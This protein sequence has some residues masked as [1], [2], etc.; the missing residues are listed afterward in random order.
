MI[1]L[2]PTL[3]R[4]QLLR[5]SALLGAAV[6]L[7]TTA[8]G[9]GDSSSGELTVW[10]MLGGAD[11]RWS[12]V[13]KQY[14][15]TFA[16]AGGGVQV[17]HIN[18]TNDSTTYPQLLQS[19]FQA[20]SGPDVIM[21]Q[22]AGDGVLT[23]AEGLRPLDDYISAELMSAVSGW[24]DNSIDGSIYGASL[25]IQGQVLYY[26]RALLQEAGLNPDD[27]PRTY[28]DLLAAC[29]RLQ[30]AGIVPIAGGNGATGDLSV[31]V[32]ST[33]FPGVATPEDA[34]ALGAN[35]ISFSDDRVVRT[36]EAYAQLVEEGHF[37]DTVLADDLDTGVQN[38]QLGRGAFSFC[39][40]TA[41]SVFSDGGGVEGLTGVGVDNLGTVVGMGLDSD[42]ANYI[43]VGPNI[44]WTMPE[45]TEQ[46]ETAGAYIA[47]TLAL[48]VQQ[49]LYN[50]AGW[51]PSN[52]EVDFT[53][54]PGERYPAMIPMLDALLDAPV[55]QLPA[56]QLWPAATAGEFKRQMQSVLNGSS[57]IS[58]AL[59]G[60][61]TVHDQQS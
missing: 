27:P 49:Q 28:A 41:L 45:F 13:M 32:F 7:P 48:D 24:E 55:T 37:G 14:D 33:L 5:L 22:P 18:Q 10:D 58:Q 1:G 20:Q 31:W 50:D 59:E 12:D 4:R 30:A 56:H 54:G 51:L 16:A 43:P 23:Y 2:N 40:A 26:N 25:G 29:S 47:G 35:E 15:L 3:D 6:V 57:S 61:Q 44:T 34:A 21:M 60:V 9:G 19:A 17:D 52:S 38:F 53:S 46:T 11:E 42:D 36:V 8:C 39:I